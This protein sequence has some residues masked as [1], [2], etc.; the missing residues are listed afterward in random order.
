MKNAFEMGSRGMIY[1]HTKFH[2]DWFS[3][4]EVNGGIHRHTGNMEIA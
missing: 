2:K 3:H 4:S 1:V